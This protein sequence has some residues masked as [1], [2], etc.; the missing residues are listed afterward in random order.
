[1]ALMLFDYRNSSAGRLFLVIALL[2]CFSFASAVMLS[3]I[4]IAALTRGLHSRSFSSMSATVRRFFL[5]SSSRA[6]KAASKIASVAPAFD[7]ITYA[8]RHIRLAFA[9]QTD[10]APQD[11]PLG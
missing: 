2:F 6:A 7:P 1:M 9:A 11:I 8:A 4:L 5:R 3:A 10:L